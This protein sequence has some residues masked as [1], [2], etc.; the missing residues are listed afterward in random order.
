MRVLL[1]GDVNGRPGRK[2]VTQI[3]PSLNNLYQDIDFV[4]ANGENAASGFGI[5]DKSANELFAAG[6]DVITMGNHTWDNRGINIIVKSENRLL[7]PANYTEDVPGF[8]YGVYESHKL[9]KRIAVVSLLGRTEMRPILDCPF[10][11]MDAL[12]PKL[13]KLGAELI[14]V[15]FHAEAT[16]EKVALGWHLDGRVTCVF[17]TH[18]HIQTNDNRLLKKGTAYITDLGMT[19]G[20]DGV[21]GVKVESV[22]PRFLNGM[23][24]RF[25][26]CEE[27]VML[28]GTLVQIDDKT[29][30]VLSIDL[31]KEK[32]KT[33]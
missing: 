21:I 4:I 19:G 17:G 28:H 27:N 23:P 32:M 33:E 26:V 13:R 11:T 15:D 10:K 12:I 20:Q 16:S 24:T 9:L 31:I 22:L 7:R 3:I 6:V 18:T 25:E 8:G 14:F 29:N 5:T 1:V 30:E 2:A